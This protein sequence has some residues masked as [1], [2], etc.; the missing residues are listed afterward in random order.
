MARARVVRLAAGARLVHLAGTDFDETLHPAR[1][2]EG[3]EG[4]G[5]GIRREATARAETDMSARAI[6]QEIK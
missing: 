3:G 5:G 6:A 4:L 2:P 1:A